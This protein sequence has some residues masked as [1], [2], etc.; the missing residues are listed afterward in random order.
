MCYAIC[1]LGITRGVD[2]C[3]EDPDV[4][5]LETQAVSVTDLSGI[6]CCHTNRSPQLNDR[7]LLGNHDDASL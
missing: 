4:Q 5:C 7:R 3:L 2:V 1:A 6:I